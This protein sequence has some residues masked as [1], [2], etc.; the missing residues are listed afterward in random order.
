MFE[1]ELNPNSLNKDFL[2]KIRR[3]DKESEDALP[4]TDLP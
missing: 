4:R 2:G 1:E 3:V